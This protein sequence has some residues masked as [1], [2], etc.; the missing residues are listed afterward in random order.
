MKGPG[1]IG[2]LAEWT[3]GDTAY[4]SIAFTWLLD[5]AWRRARWYKELGYRVLAGGP[6]LFTR[7]HYLADVAE[8]G[9]SYPDAIYRH[10]PLATFASRGCPVGCFWCIVPKM[11]GKEFTE[12]P[13]FQVR[14]I[15]CDNNLSALPTDYQEY[16]VKRYE[17]A[18]V[19]LLDANS[20]FEPAKFDDETLARWGRVNKGPWR[21]GYDK[22]ARTDD[23]ERVMKL[24]HRYPAKR[25]RPY[26][27]IGTEPVAE[28]LDRINRVIGWGGEPHV[29]AYIKLN[30]LT[31]E[32]NVRYDW[33][34]QLLTDMRRW[35][36]RRIWRYASF[37]EYRRSAKTSRDDRYDARQGM[38]I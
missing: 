20:G 15:L 18:G 23:L 22:S 10:N 32:P 4:L 21:F 12:F 17:A 11:E 5:D 34:P 35:A 2:G 29:Q 13:D 30:S 36:D 33:T 38:F 27:M 19:P 8:L 7:K 9:G 31:K 16:I 3:E 14:P 1:W 28:C 6:G 24:L 26:V 37:A 25:K